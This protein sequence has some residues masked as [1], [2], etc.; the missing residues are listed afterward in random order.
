M[1][2]TSSPFATSRIVPEITIIRYFV[3]NE[4]VPLSAGVQLEQLTNIYR[5]TGTTIN[6]V[7][8]PVRKVDFFL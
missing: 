8:D 1:L 3:Q 6:F 4:R 7:L 2:R 5:N